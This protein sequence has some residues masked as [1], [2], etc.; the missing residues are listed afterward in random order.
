[1]KDN[2][3]RADSDTSMTSQLLSGTTWITLA[4]GLLLPTGFITLTFLTRQLGADGYGLFA[5]SATLITWI[6]WESILS[7]P[8]QR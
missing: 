7:F 5:L 6:E 1:M 8:V 4:E 2:S 3:A